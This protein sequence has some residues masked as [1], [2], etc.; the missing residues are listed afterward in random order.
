MWSLGKQREYC[1]KARVDVSQRGETVA[2]LRRVDS[3]E[4][5]Q[6]RLCCTFVK[7]KRWYSAWIVL[8]T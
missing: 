2:E 8:G 7:T 4:N 1:P 3:N 5:I 6:G